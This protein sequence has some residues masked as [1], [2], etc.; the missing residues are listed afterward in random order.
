MPKEIRFSKLVEDSGKPETATLW[1]K[2]EMDL[3]LQEALK[4]N[5]I[6]T[7]LQHPGTGKKDF[8]QIGLHPQKSAIY[9]AAS[10]AV[11]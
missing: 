1:V 10:A 9:L 7:V 8:G 6:L 4:T 2:P 5:R 3:H 11:F